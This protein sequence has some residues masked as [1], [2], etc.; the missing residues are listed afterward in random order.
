MGLKIKSGTAVCK[1]NAPLY[2]WGE[3]ISGSAQVLLLVLWLEITPGRPSGPGDQTWV[4]YIQDKCLTHSAVAQPPHPSL[5]C[6][7][8]L[9][10]T[11][12]SC[13][14]VTCLYSTAFPPPFL[15]LLSLIQGL[16]L[17]TMTCLYGTAFPFPFPSFYCCYWCKEQGHTFKCQAVVLTLSSGTYQRLL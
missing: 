4:G 12:N 15:S 7:P 13:C 14:S 11:F 9:T 8:S 10:T 6:C 5:Y 3:G 1:A 17:H 16:E 2:I